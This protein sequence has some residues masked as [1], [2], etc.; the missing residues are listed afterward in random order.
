MDW[1]ALRARLQGREALL[2]GAVLVVI[3]TLWAFL[4]IADEVMEGETRAADMAILY[5]LREGGDP[6]NPV[7]PRWLEEA[8]RDITALG[9]GAVL[10]L[11]VLAVSGFLILRGQ[12][13]GL[14]LLLA[15]SLGG[16]MLTTSLKG[17]FGRPR[18]EFAAHSVEELSYSFPSGHSLM[19]AVVYLSTGALLASLARHRGHKVYILA[20]AMAL[21]GL[22]G[23]SRIYLGVHYPTDVAAGWT[24]GLAWAAL[25]WIAAEVLKVRGAADP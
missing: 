18:P 22:V 15:A 10:I 24:I 14:V 9:S 12:I 23:A 25:C 5:A 16:S 13:N 17:F 19:S 2:L 6:G 7:G 20:V 8:F 11:V 3:G 1:P 4:E 21:S